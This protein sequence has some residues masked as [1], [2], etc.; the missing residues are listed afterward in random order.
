MLARVSCI[1][2]N[3][4]TGLRSSFQP[5]LGIEIH[6]LW[7]TQIHRLWGTQSEMNID[8]ESPESCRPFKAFCRNSM[9]VVT[10]VP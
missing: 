3:D 5:V 9:T 4:V 8:I 10:A 1:T 7:G 6:R 2:N